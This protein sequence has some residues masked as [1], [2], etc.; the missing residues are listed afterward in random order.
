VHPWYRESGLGA[1]AQLGGLILLAVVLAL[2]RRADKGLLWGSIGLHGSLVGGFFILQHGLV[3]I[4][5]DAPE[6]LVGA[7]MPTPNPISGLVGWGSLLLVLWIRRRV[8]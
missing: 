4:S 3:Q 8:W 1:V 2:Q 5:P 6:W 7:G